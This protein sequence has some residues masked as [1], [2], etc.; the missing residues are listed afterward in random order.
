M[1]L[2]KKALSTG[3]TDNPARADRTF[4]AGRPVPLFQTE[5]TVN[6]A[7][8]DR[9]HR[10]DVT[11]AGRDSRQQARCRTC[12]GRGELAVGIQEMNGAMLEFMRFL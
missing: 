2:L 4:E 6:R 3:R 5:L 9:D 11:Q 12:H 8:P 1:E 10:Y 7:R